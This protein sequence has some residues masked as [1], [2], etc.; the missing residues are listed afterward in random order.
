MLERFDKLKNFVKKL[1]PD[2]ELDSN[3]DDSIKMN[4]IKMN[5]IK[6]NENEY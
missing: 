5:K 3:F 4:E 2:L 1:F 6:M